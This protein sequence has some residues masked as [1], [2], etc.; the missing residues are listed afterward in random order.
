MSTEYSRG[1]ESVAWSAMCLALTALTLGCEPAGFT[2]PRNAERVG[3]LDLYLPDAERTALPDPSLWSDT[4]S[5]IDVRVE[6]VGAYDYDVHFDV[7]GTDAVR[8]VILDFGADG[9]Y[10]VAPTPTP[11]DA[12][13]TA[14]GIAASQLGVTCSSACLSACGCLQCSDSVAE[15]N[16]EQACALNCTLLS[17]NMGLAGEPYNGSEQVYADLLYRGSEEYGLVGVAAQLGCGVSACGETA[18]TRTRVTFSV[19]FVLPELSQATLNF[20]PQVVA[21]D[22]PYV[23]PPAGAAMISHCIY[24]TYTQCPGR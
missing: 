17:D 4:L 2:V 6:Q 5:I 23:S 3:D 7:E 12:P 14:C 19:R 1:F 16:A 21:D 15:L 20:V 8:F 10:R 24:G 13:P 22:T 9:V 18:G 11:P